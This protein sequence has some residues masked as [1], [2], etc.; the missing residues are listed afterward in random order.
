VGKVGDDKSWEPTV[1]AGGFVEADMRKNCY[2]REIKSFTPVLA[3]HKFKRHDKVQVTDKYSRFFGVAGVVVGIKPNIEAVRIKY[4]TPQEDEEY[5][6]SWFWENELDL[7]QE[8]KSSVPAL[9]VGDRVRSRQGLKGKITAIDDTRPFPIS[10]NIDEYLHVNYSANELELIQEVKEN[11][12]EPLYRFL[13]EGEQI[14][15]GDLYVDPLRS[16]N[17]GKLVPHTLGNHYLRKVN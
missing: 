12:E 3:G 17:V 9:K 2:R 13:Q 4:D 15:K 5:K 14:Q 10:V 11:P 16:N 1:R 8:V 7:V 6:Y